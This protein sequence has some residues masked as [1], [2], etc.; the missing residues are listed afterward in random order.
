[1]SCELQGSVIGPGVS[2]KLNFGVSDLVVHRDS[3]GRL[4]I[5]IEIEHPAHGAFAMAHVLWGGE[6]LTWNFFS[7]L[8][9]V[10]PTQD[11]GITRQSSGQ[12]QE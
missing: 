4:G 5:I 3:L 12:T 1:M 9:L 11:R 6:R 8:A 2:K 7:S 10:Q